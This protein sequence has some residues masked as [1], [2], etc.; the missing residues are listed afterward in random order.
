[1][2]LVEGVDTESRDARHFE[3]KVGFE[4]FLEVL[5]LLVIHDVIN[6]GVDF[7]VL[8]GWQIDASDVTIDTNHRRQSGR[9]VE[10][11]GSLFGGEREQFSNIHGIPRYGAV[12]IGQ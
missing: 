10:V 3:G 2:V 11:G 5:A 6:E 9:Q 12:N 1:T 7:L 8:E 4:E